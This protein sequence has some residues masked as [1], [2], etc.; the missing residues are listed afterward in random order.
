MDLVHPIRERN[1]RPTNLYIPLCFMLYK[2]ALVTKMVCLTNNYFIDDPSI[3]ATFASGKT[4]WHDFPASAYTSV[5]SLVW[6]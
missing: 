2:L 4:V 6:N 1:I 3:T 5:L